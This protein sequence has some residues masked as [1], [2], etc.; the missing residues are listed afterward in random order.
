MKPVFALLALSLLGGPAKAELRQYGPLNV[1][2]SQSKTMNGAI[3]LRATNS[4]DQVLFVGAYCDK[5]L[6]NYTGA[7]YKWKTWSKP[8]TANEEQLVVDLCNL[9]SQ[10]VNPQ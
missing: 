2:F 1:D 6:F 8:A 9:A 3:M 5:R 4:R 7:E 10:S